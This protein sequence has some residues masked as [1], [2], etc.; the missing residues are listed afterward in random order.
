MADEDRHDPSDTGEEL[1][2]SDFYR[3]GGEFDPHRTARTTSSIDIRN[4]YRTEAEREAARTTN[5]LHLE[6]YLRTG[7]DGLH[8]PDALHGG[9]AHH[10]YDAHEWQHEEHPQAAAPAA[11]QPPQAVPPPPQASEPAAEEDPLSIAAAAEAEHDASP[12]GSA[13]APAPLPPPAAPPVNTIYRFASIGALLGIVFGA[14]AIMLSWVFSSPSGP[15]DLGVQTLAAVGLKGRL[16]TKWEDKKLQYRL[17]FSPSDDEDKAGFSWVVGNPP[18]PLAIDIQLK[19][20]MGFVLCSRNILLPFDPAA[21][22][23]TA[24]DPA[25]PG[26]Q[27]TPPPDLDQLKADEAHREHG[28]ELFQLQAG[29]SGQIESVAAQGVFPCSEQAY[30]KVVSW[31]FTPDYPSVAEQNDLMRQPEIQAAARAAALRRKATAKKVQ[32]PLNFVLEGDNVLVGYD[33]AAGAFETS[34]G[35]PF[36]VDKD[37]ATLAQS[38][39]QTFPI[40]IHYRCDSVSGCTLTRVGS[41]AQLRARMK[42]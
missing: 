37:S 38:G 20:A 7:P 10:D 16:Y 19:D 30:E 33:A 31:S 12:A 5:S 40:H 3:D 15:Y 34:S 27:N 41:T 18:R 26:Q 36:Y 1:D 25:R 24:P 2:L 29:S 23:Q 21:A 8:D 35:S 11:P 28:Q 6:D 39:W 17:S 22:A 14:V 4:Y 13:G 42:R 32:G 9:A